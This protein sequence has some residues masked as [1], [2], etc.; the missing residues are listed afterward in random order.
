MLEPTTTLATRILARAREMRLEDELPR[1]AR[2]DQA[3]VANIVGGRL[4]LKGF[5]AAPEW[6]P[7]EMLHP[8]LPLEIAE[9]WEGF[10]RNIVLDALDEGLLT[11]GRAREL[12][13]WG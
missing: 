11:V 1:L 2:L 4:D 5:V 13:T 7:L 8:D 3:R 12:L 6:V 9:I 10:A